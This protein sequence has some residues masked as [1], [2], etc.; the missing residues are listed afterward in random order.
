[1]CYLVCFFL[2]VFVSFSS[3]FLFLPLVCCFLLF[4][5]F[6]L[7]PHPCPAELQAKERHVKASMEGLKK[8]A[9]FYKNDPV[10]SC[11]SLSSCC[12]L[13]L[14]VVVVCCSLSSCC[15]LLLFVVVCCCLLLFVVCCC[16]LLFVV[17]C[18]ANDVIF[19]T[20]LAGKERNRREVQR[21]RDR[22]SFAVECN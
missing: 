13:L 15:C 18:L 19:L 7:S 3:C 6:F 4:F 5:C 8:L 10:V 20:P 11:C 17:C 2:F 1:M 12:C 14:F 22:V 21:V 9:G 16:L